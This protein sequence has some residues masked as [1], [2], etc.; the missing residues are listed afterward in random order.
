MPSLHT[1]ISQLKKSSSRQ[2]VVISLPCKYDRWT[3]AS[4]ESHS[5]H[6][7]LQRTAVRVVDELDHKTTVAWKI[8]LQFDNQ[9]TVFNKAPC[10][11]YFISYYMLELFLELSFNLFL[12]AAFVPNVLARWTSL[13]PCSAK[14]NN[15]LLWFFYFLWPDAPQ[16]CYQ[17]GK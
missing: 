10:H 6:A 14:H 8:N 16:H 7:I 11:S 17:G 5:L 4:I 13:S 12:S 1:K 2:P 3:A 9:S 15:V